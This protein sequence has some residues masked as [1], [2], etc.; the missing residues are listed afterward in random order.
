MFSLQ[1]DAQ[2]MMRSHRPTVE[3]AYYL[4]E[5]SPY[6]RLA[7]ADFT[8]RTSSATGCGGGDMAFRQPQGVQITS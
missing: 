4:W 6:G 3:A 1:D 2:R 5:K 8:T 7:C